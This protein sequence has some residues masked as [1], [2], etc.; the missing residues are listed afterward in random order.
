MLYAM[1]DDFRGKNL[2]IGDMVA[3]VMPERKVLAEGVLFGTTGKSLRIV[4][5]KGGKKVVIT[6]SHAQVVLIKRRGE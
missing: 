5:Q 1:F 3:F 4:V 6:R 2:S